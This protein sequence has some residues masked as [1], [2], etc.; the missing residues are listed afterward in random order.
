MAS[1]K[2]SLAQ[3]LTE[4]GIDLKEKQDICDI[5]RKLKTATDKAETQCK[6]MTKH[7]SYTVL[8]ERLN[9]YE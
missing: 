7:L 6:C 2:L 9:R 8:Q 3:Y 5:Y 4:I 1:V